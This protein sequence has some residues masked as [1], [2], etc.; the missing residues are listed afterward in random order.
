VRVQICPLDD[1]DQVAQYVAFAATVFDYS[2]TFDAISLIGA[3]LG[4]ATRDL[5]AVRSISVPLLGAGAGGLAP[6]AVVRQLKEAFEK[7]G[8]QGAVLSIFV[9]R[10][11]DY[12]SL[13]SMFEDETPSRTAPETHRLRSI[14]WL[15]P[16]TLASLGAPSRSVSHPRP[17]FHEVLGRGARLW[18]DAGA[19]ERSAG[20]QETPGGM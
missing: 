13:A 4:E 5:R 11:T 8:A 3:A 6:A 20:C 10:H 14:T 9:L 16:P 12:R 18:R 7:H 1:A 15:G 19:G 2:S 17:G